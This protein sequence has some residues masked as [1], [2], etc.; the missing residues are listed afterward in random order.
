MSEL[1][2]D[3]MMAL[4]ER[5]YPICRSITGDGVR[6]S[7]SILQEQIPLEIHEVPSGEKVFD[8]TVP[9]E[10]NIRDAWIK[11]SKGERLVDFQ[12]LNL[13][14]VSYSV[15]VQAR[16]RLSEL[17]THLFSLPGQPDRVPYRTS[18]YSETW[19]FCLSEQQLARFNENDEYD[20]FIDSSLTPG[21]LTY[22]EYLLPGA[23]SEEVL[24]STHICHPSL[25]DDNLSGIAVA[26]A[27]A[28]E[29]ARIS[30]R[31]SY[32]F[33]F[34]PGSIGAITWLARNER[35]LAKIRCGLVL[36]CVG[37]SAPLTYKRSRHGNAEID[38]AFAQVLRHSGARH[39]IVDFSPYGYDERQYNSPGINLPIGCLM[40]SVH[41]TF[42]EYH[43]SGDNLSF[44]HPAALED[45]L[46]KCLAAFA[47]LERNETYLNQHPKGEPQLGRRG[48]YQGLGAGAE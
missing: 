5:L 3:A 20:V 8:W 27:L 33:I 25:A 34:V 1:S 13:H 35:Q 11:N 41:G 23:S 39:E 38:R 24:I 16:L 40:R 6:Q 14:V 17:R 12:K 31:Y 43:T 10:W 32:R 44:V 9:P 42:P 4:I 30:R 2:A 47:V 21:H 26:V 7:L 37:D 45:S 48:L 29:I 28:R 15:P 46:Q 22:G 18:Y 19:G 36:T